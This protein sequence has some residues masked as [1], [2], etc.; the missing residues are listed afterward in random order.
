MRFVCLASFRAGLK[1]LLH[2]SGHNTVT[3][4]QRRERGFGDNNEKGTF[5]FLTT[6]VRH[7]QNNY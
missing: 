3:V 7:D 2:P 5:I 1:I 4:Q 6:N